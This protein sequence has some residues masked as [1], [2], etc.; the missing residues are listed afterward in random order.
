MALPDFV[1]HLR[2]AAQKLVGA[3]DAPAYQSHSARELQHPT[4]QRF[5]S[6]Q[7]TGPSLPMVGLRGLTWLGLG[8]TV[9]IGKGLIEIRD[10]MAYFHAG[11]C[12]PQHHEPAAVDLQL[13]IGS[14][15]QTPAARELPYWP[16]YAQLTPDQ[17]RIYLNWL[18]SGRRSVPPEL[19]YT[20]LYIY[21]LERRALLDR[22]D[23]KTIFKEILRLRQVYARSGLPPSR[24]FEGYTASFIWCLLLRESAALEKRH[25]EFF[26]KSACRWDE[27]CL[28][29]AMSWLTRA[30]EPLPDW[31]AFALAPQLPN[32]Q[33]SVVTKRVGNELEELFCKR[34]SEHFGTGFVLKA[35]KPDRKFSYRPASSALQPVEVTVP[36]ARGIISQFKPLSEIWNSCIGDLKRFSSVMAGSQDGAMNVAAWNAMPAELKAGIDHPLIDA[37]THFIEEHT[38][39]NPQTI[40]LARELATLAGVATAAKLTAAACRRMA[41]TISNVGYC[42]EPD[43]RITGRGYEADESVVLFLNLGDGDVEQNRYTVASTMLNV[44][45]TLA[46]SDANA[47]ESELSKLTDQIDSSFGL[48]EHERRRLDKLRALR[49]GHPPEI[50][51]VMKPLKRLPVPE[52]QQL[53]KF[54]LALVAADGV[55]TRDERK[56]IHRLYR[57][58]GFEPSQADAQLASLTAPETAHDDPVSVMS[59]VAG[60]PGEPIPSQPGVAATQGLRLNRDAINAILKDT[61]DVAQMLADA[62]NVDREPESVKATATEKGEV[63]T[64]VLRIEAAVSH[65]PPTQYK[66]FFEAVI[67]QTQWMRE[68]LIVLAKEHGLMLAGAVDAINDWSTDVNGGPLLYEDGQQF[69]LETAYLSQGL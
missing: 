1:D 11:P 51:E 20:F 21:G 2:S 40:V 58:L 60:E 13:P 42:I 9:R 8:N 22:Q 37:F 12:L 61:S 4:P 44:G 23:V 49:I 17:R 29:S 67:K 69:T 16:Q 53:A 52:R 28:A 59:A 7:T 15:P 47:V 3:N 27:N 48:N 38:G 34:F 31:L 18:A 33:H 19:G 30:N 64:Q 62:M 10:P 14:N 46:N 32:S 55:I 5:V 68:E 6:P 45:V 56:A 66:A 36:D 57:G 26:A 25:F 41:E 35:S 39:D 43:C 65:G 54:A 50:S 63:A 24:S